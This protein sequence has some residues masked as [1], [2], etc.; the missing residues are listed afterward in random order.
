MIVP[1]VCSP[2][3]TPSPSQA[4]SPIASAPTSS[5]IPPSM[6]PV[7]QTSSTSMTPLIA[8]TTVG[9]VAILMTTAIVLF[10]AWRRKRK[11]EQVTPQQRQPA[12]PSYVI[13]PFTQVAARVE[14]EG[15]SGSHSMT[16]RC[17]FCFSCTHLVQ[18]RDQIS[19]CRSQAAPVLP[20]YESSKGTQPGPGTISDPSPTSDRPPRPPIRD[21]A[22]A[23]PQNRERPE[24]HRGDAILNHSVTDLRQAVAHINNLL[25]SVMRSRSDAP[26]G[27]NE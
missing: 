14:S 5:L 6:S 3:M 19:Y 20:K 18:I 2:S 25:E 10:C 11:R 8:G 17:V 9:A 7:G 16:M 4:P 23:S 22:M 21:G 24:E 27:Y 26:P 12:D 1:D 13:E 15:G